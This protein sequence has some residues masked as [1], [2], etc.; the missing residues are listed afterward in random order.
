MQAQAVGHM[1]AQKQHEVITE[2]KLQ[3]KGNEVFY[4]V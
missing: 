3:E 1:Q 4:L 2:E